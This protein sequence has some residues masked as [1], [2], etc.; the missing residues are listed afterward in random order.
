[1]WIDRSLE[2]KL[3]ERARSRP[4]VVLTGAR[5]TGKTTLV[6][7]VFPE[8]RYVSLDLPSEAEQAEADPRVFLSRHPSPLIVDEIQYAP[9]LLRHLKTEV[10]AERDRNGQFI[11]TG[12]QPFVLMKGVGESL[13]GRAAVLNLEGLS[14]DEIRRSN[15][16]ESVETFVVRGGYP[17]L[18]EK[19]ELDAP[20]FY[21]SY[22]ATYLERDLRSQ[23][24]VGSLRD[25]ERFLRAC[26]LRTAQVLNKAELARDVGISPSTANEWLSVLESSGIISLLE[27]WFSNSTKSL[28]KAPKLHFLDTGLCAF[29][30]GMESVADLYDSP[31]TG[32]LW[33]TAVF[34]ELRRLL[35]VQG[36]WQLGYWRD[37]TK[38]AD[39]LL[40]KA[41]RFIL[42]DAKWSEHPSN[43]GKLVRICR[44]LDPSPPIALI[45]R[46][47][48]AYPLKDGTQ[49][50]PLSDLAAFLGGK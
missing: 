46:T 43:G 24:Q 5:Q 16:E 13:A 28:V 6:R 40:H 42:V 39:F 37:R 32:A 15:P 48:N 26:A 38:E 19:P 23:L 8:H 1:M 29:L 22:V 47:P 12:S 45:C 25:F 36:G 17:E 27:P 30:M 10:D 31:L 14:F 11:L 44:E 20:G 18:Y 3:V 9:G 41:G 21:Q 7:R 2:V 50:L 49:A 35:A 33:E 4:V 34:T